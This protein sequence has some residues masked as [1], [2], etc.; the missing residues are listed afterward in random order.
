[1]QWHYFYCRL[2]ISDTPLSNDRTVTLV[3]VFRDALFFSIDVASRWSSEAF[4][5]ESAGHNRVLTS[6]SKIL[7][8]GGSIEFFRCPQS[9]PRCI[10]LH[11]EESRGDKQGSARKMDGSIVKK[12][13]IFQ[14][15]IYIMAIRENLFLLTRTRLRSTKRT[16]SCK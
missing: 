7:K 16:R 15:A 13:Y 9:L 1:M 6:R 4:D 12:R 14:E 8:S 11:F 10:R 3:E 2:L 5:Q